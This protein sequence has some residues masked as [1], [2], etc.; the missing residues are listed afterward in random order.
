MG[1]GS[2]AWVMS[3]DASE[4]PNARSE[5]MKIMNM[6]ILIKCPNFGTSHF[7]PEQ[8]G[9]KGLRARKMSKKIE[10]LIEEEGDENEAK[11]SLTR[12]LAPSAMHKTH[13]PTD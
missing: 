3:L 13:E 4:T 2:R 5:W 1:L 11:F 7:H 9:E 8:V 12:H 10:S 6:M